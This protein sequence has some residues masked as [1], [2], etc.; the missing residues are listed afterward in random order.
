MELYLTRVTLDPRR[1]AV[2]ELSR[3]VYEAHRTVMAAFP[4]RP[5]SA[6]RSEFGVLWRHETGRAP[7]LLVQ[8]LVEPDR[9]AWSGLGSEVVTKRI[10]GMLRRALTPGRLLRFR[11]RANPT[12]KID[13]KTGPDGARRH[14]RRVPLRGD[15]DRILWIVRRLGSAGA[16]VVALNGVPDVRVEGS[17]LLRGRGNGRTVTVEAVDF[18]GRLVVDDPGRLLD[19]IGLG[20]GPAKA[21]GMG[22]VMLAP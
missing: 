5:G 11:L 6:A 4:D 19:S 17:G 9:S 13:T 12:R 1:R 8:S 16:P 20:V 2:R 22:L 15:G 21:F 3:D 14:G 7:A 18:A 10:D